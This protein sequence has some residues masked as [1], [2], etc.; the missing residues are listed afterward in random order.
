MTDKIRYGKLIIIEEVEKRKG[1]PKKVIC[2]CDCGSNPREY[3]LIHLKSGHTKTC[4]CY[5]PELKSFSGYKYNRITIIEEI[6]RDKHNHRMVVGKCDCGNIKKFVLSSIKSGRIRSCGCLAREKTK[7]CHQNKREI[8]IG[9]RYGRLVVIK[10]TGIKKNK[11]MVFAKCDCGNVK[12]YA[13]NTLRSNG[14]RSCGCYRLESLRDKAYLKKDYEEKYPF[15][16]KIED[17]MDAPSGYGIMVR[18]KKCNKWF[19]PTSNQIIARVVAVENPKKAEECNF[20]CSDKCK[21]SC[22]LF[23]RRGDPFAQNDKPRST[24]IKI[25]RK[26]VLKRQFDEY[27]RNFCEIC[28]SESNLQIHHDIPQKINPLFSLDPDNGIIL[29]HKCHVKKT[30]IGWCGMSTLSNK[31]CW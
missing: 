12:E 23:R 15:F 7:A 22:I 21:H 3:Q 30:H 10:E 19:R 8:C 20:Y 6:E 13:L 27:G 18:C 1:E 4:G 29:C 11:R 5:K 25:F 31:I 9:E 16:F 17:I 2:Q 14:A 24:E 26:E 28:E